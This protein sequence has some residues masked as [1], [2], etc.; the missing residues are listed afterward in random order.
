VKNSRTLCIGIV[1]GTVSI[2]AAAENGAEFQYFRSDGGVAKSA[3][4]FPSDLD[5]PEALRWRVPLDSGHSSPI[6]HKGKIFLTTWR[7]QSRELA[8]VALDEATGKVLWRNPIVPE[9]VEQ[10]NPSGNPATAT[11][12][13][14]GQRLFVFFGSFG[15][16]CYDLDGHKLWEQ[17]L[18]PFQDEYGA[19]SSP[20]LF[21]GK[22]IISQDHDADSFLVA[23]DCATGRVAWKVPR[24][25][26]VRSYSTPAIWMHEGH[27][28]LLIPGALQLTA[29]N[30]ANGDRLWWLNGLARIVIPAPVTSGPV[31]YMASWSPGGDIGKR[32][33]FLS[34]TNALAK[35]DGNSDGQLAKKEID[36]REVL[37]RFNR[38]DL[39][40][41]GMLNQLE[42][43]RQAAVFQRA[44]N[45]VLA[46]KP[47]GRGELPQSSVI[48]KH[49]KGIPYVATPVLD[50]GLLWMVKD[51]G[52]VTKLDADTGKV[53]QEE[54][55][56]AVGNYYASPVAADGKIYFA[57][58]TGTL[59]VVASQPEWRVISSR[60]F[61]EKI[62]ATPALNRGRLYLRTEQSLFCFEGSQKQ[63][64]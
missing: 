6:L 10:V 40:K 21:D 24:P 62:Y 49:T 58:E 29:Y 33:S 43:E 8:T 37:E 57:G 46:L 2:A 4:P 30:P 53:L 20:I 39:D 47:A 56:P 52:I 35:W 55:L 25:D 9:R 14:D 59:S 12:A 36:D 41:N 18:G 3:E 42:W 44:Q 26:A 63:K 16:L 60:D 31:I 38:M 51:G 11:T 45:A 15:M 28:E 64:E 7:L 61:H 1:L 19:G 32:V 13:C 5:A 48:W 50:H 34:W 23:M 54:R 17:R 22:V 27:P